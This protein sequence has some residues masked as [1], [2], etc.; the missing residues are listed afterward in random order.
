MKALYKIEKEISQ[1]SITHI[2]FLLFDAIK[3]I[4][5]LPKTIIAFSNNTPFII[6]PHP[7]LMGYPSCGNDL[8]NLVIR[9]LTQIREGAVQDQKE[10]VY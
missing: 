3:I 1:D 9:N 6:Q 2:S 4:L 10:N 8:L 5:F 7:S